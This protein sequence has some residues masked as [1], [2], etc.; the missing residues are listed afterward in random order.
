ML[1]KGACVSRIT[2]LDECQVIPLKT[3]IL[4]E[5]VEVLLL[6]SFLAND[7]LFLSKVREGLV[8]GHKLVKLFLEVHRVQFD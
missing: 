4:G 6:K 5:E 8:R 1:T 7:D 3:L 2:L